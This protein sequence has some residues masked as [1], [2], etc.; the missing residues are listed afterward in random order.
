MS[1]NH[2]YIEFDSRVVK[3]YAKTTV[4]MLTGY[5]IDPKRPEN[6]VA[7]ML[8]SPRASFHHEWR[9]GEKP[10][11]VRADFKYEDEIIELYSEDE[12]RLFERWNRRNIEE[13]LLKVYDA[14]APDVSTINLVSDEELDK[15]AQYK[16]NARIV[17]KVN[18]Y[19]SV[20][21]LRRLL[22]AVEKHDRSYSIIKLINERINELSRSN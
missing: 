19:T 2:Q 20:H 14:A 13:G 16:Q 6:R 10:V 8:S 21:T 18:E 22:S 4:G 1:H 7:W 12:I 17:E 9:D 11:L 3:R 15:V 5:R